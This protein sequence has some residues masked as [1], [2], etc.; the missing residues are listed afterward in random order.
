M[1]ACE[2]GHG[3]LI[4]PNTEKIHLGGYLRGITSSKSHLFI[5]SSK[6]RIKSRSQGTLNEGSINNHNEESCVI[7][8]LEKG[9]NHQSI[10]VDL[11]SYGTEIYDLATLDVDIPS[12]MVK[13]DSLN[14]SITHLQKKI[15]NLEIKLQ[16]KSL[17]NR[18]KNLLG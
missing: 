14:L 5:G 16:E 12:W 13:Q 4:L 2:S 9:T 6:M 7:K 10:L 11:S 8:T 17:I 3:K 1:Y 18:L 15:M